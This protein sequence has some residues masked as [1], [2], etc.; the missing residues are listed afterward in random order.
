MSSNLKPE[1]LAAA[2]W[3]HPVRRLPELRFLRWAQEVVVPAWKAGQR[4]HRGVMGQLQRN[5]PAG[6]AQ[7][8]GHEVGPVG[9]ID[10]GLR[11]TVVQGV[12]SLLGC[13]AQGLRH[14]CEVW[15]KLR[16][17][18]GTKDDSFSRWGLDP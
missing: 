2:L 18:T 16:I 11:K 14:F 12:N 13:A 5:R 4:E 3:V 8:N 15:G 7:A 10:A 1:P 17:E 6:D 9:G